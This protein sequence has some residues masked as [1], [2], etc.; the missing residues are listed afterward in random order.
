M[1]LEVG[2]YQSYIVGGIV[3]PSV[4]GG[5]IDNMGPSVHIIYHNKTCEIVLLRRLSLSQRV[6]YHFGAFVI[7]LIVTKVTADLNDK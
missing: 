1:F 5:S 3:G 4:L 6:H 7:T 2:S